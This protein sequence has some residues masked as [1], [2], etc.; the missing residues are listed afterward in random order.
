MNLRQLVRRV[1]AIDSTLHLIAIVIVLLLIL[2]SLILHV[3]G[4]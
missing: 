1:V 2:A 3:I 4:G